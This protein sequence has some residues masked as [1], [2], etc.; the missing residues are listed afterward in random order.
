M[1][2]LC[3]NRQDREE[4]KKG[5]CVRRRID[6]CLVNHFWSQYAIP[7]NSIKGIFWNGKI[8]VWRE[9]TSGAQSCSCS[10]QKVDMLLFSSDPLAYCCENLR[11]DPATFHNGIAS[12]FS[13][14]SVENVA[15]SC[16]P[17]NIFHPQT[18]VHR[19]HPSRNPRS[20][21]S[22]I[23]EYCPTKVFHSVKQIFPFPSHS[24][25]PNHP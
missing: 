2:G 25:R 14:Q 21:F 8:C 5:Q 19:R 12:M 22:H 7:D 20:S 11:N 9:E 18:L 13:F 16:I 10:A 6:Y 3:R 23:K 4:K 15:P 24:I 1:Q 17:R